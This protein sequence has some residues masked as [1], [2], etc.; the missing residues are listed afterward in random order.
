MF[1]TG[2]ERPQHPVR[3]SLGLGGDVLV[4]GWDDTYIPSN[5]VAA[6]QD[7]FIAHFGI[8]PGPGH[9]ISLSSLVYAFPPA[10]NAPFSAANAVAAERDGSGASYLASL[11]PSNGTQHGIV[12]TKFRADQTVAWDDAISNIP[13]DAVTALALSPDRRAVRHRGHLRRARRQGL[14]PGG[15]LPPED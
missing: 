5:Y 3:L 13:F 1:E 10:A 12:V 7:G 2:N 9:A 11:I 4:A 8:D 14:R 15:R 6:N